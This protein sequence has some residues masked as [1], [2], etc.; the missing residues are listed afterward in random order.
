[1]F[2]IIFNCLM[3][4]SWSLQI[5][6]R[7]ILFLPNLNRVMSDRIPSIQTPST[8]D[9]PSLG[10]KRLYS[11][12]CDHDI[13]H[14]P[15]KER[16]QKGTG[17]N[18]T[19]PKK[20]P[21]PMSRKVRDQP[22]STPP[23]YIVENGLRKVKPYLYVYQ[24]YA[25]QRWLGMTVF[26]VF[27]KEFHDRPAEVY[28]QAILKGRIKINGKAVPLDYVIRNSDLVEN[29]V[30]R[31]EPVIT[32]TPIEIVH[33]SDSVLVVNKPSSIPVHPTGR[34]RHNTVIHLLEYEN[35]MNDLF[36][37]N[38]I[39]RLTSGLV[40][41]ARDKNKAAYMMQEMRERRI[42][43]TYLARVKGEFPADAIECHE[44]IETVEF[45]V[46][47][48]IVSP[49]GKPCSTL[50]KR[51]SYNGL[52]SVVQCEPLTGRTHQ[53]RVHLQFLGHPIANDPIYGCSEW[54][55][56]MGKGG[57]DPKA[58]AMTANRVT[59]AVFPSEQELVDHDN[60]DDAD[61][62]PIANC[63][64]CRLKRSDPIPEQLV[65]WLHSWKYKGDS[66]WDFE[67][68]MPDW[69]HESY[70]GDQQLVDR[71]WAHGGLWDGKA[72]GHFI[73]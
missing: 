35:K 15:S 18:P 50:F 73:D 62:D 37:V 24:T 60:V 26:E 13:T 49:T 36:L 67:T 69:A 70:Q 44:P 34:Y 61:A 48:N 23:E 27:S 68:S 64:E 7:L 16:R 41:I 11:T 17:P 47:V 56:D 63:V 46:G 58:V 9:D 55:K 10:Q 12:V 21:P 39:D 20:T 71:F 45:K 42:H 57:L 22:N 2:S 28:R 66:G 31:H 40:L 38:R 8:H 3:I 54:G 14:K 53:I 51:L 32:D 30:H 5:H 29:T 59:A 52:T 1:M 43:K 19:G 4:K 25:K 72:P 33:Q 65:I 6:H